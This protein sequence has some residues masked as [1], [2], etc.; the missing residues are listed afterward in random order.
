MMSARHVLSATVERAAAGGATSL[1][2]ENGGPG[3]EERVSSDRM[4]WCDSPGGR[5]AG[6]A[7]Y[8]SGT[9][10]GEGS[11][12]R[13]GPPGT[14]QFR[15][16]FLL[17]KETDDVPALNSTPAPRPARLLQNTSGRC[18]WGIRP[19][20]IGLAGTGWR[21][22][23]QP[24]SR[25]AEKGRP[26]RSRR[27]RKAE[28]R[29]SD[30]RGGGAADL[31]NQVAEFFVS[32]DAW[33]GMAW[34]NTAGPIR[35]KDLRGKIVLLDFWTLCCINC[36]HVLPDLAK[37]EKK[38]PNELVVIGVHS[39]QVRQR[40]EHRE[41]PQG[42]PPLRDRPPGRQRRRPED[43]ERLRRPAPGRRCA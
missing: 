22:Q 26:V 23:R 5:A 14:R 42:D 1:R 35:L 28:G 8:N 41:H 7:A 30:G 29:A 18:C 21:R 13:T 33:K 38:Y 24:A 6:G 3:Q 31:V 2:A 43:L 4:V 40:E 27:R 25:A 17:A 15:P 32:G 11:A 36:I 16:T 37:L 12:R 19:S 39:R 9:A 34:L 20:P 10:S